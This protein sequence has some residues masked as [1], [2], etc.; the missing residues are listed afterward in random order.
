L[1]LKHLFHFQAIQIFLQ[2]DI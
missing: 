2:K 1:V